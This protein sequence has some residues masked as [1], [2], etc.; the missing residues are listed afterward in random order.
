M[1]YLRSTLAKA[2]KDLIEIAL[3]AADSKGKPGMI[4]VTHGY[5]YPWPDG[6][7]VLWIKGLIGPWFD[8]TF[9]AKNYPLDGLPNDLLRRRDIL[10][11]FVNALNV[12]LLKFQGNLCWSGIPC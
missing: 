4:V 9:T 3:S 6:R 5:D 1:I 12:M 7:G 10:T 11:S 8:P 2:Y